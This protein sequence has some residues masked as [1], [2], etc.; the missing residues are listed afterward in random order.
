MELVKSIGIE[1]LRQY[2][3]HKSLNSTGQY[4]KVSDQ[5]ASAAVA[6]AMNF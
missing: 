5:T 4:L 3:G 1:D 2:I 6:K